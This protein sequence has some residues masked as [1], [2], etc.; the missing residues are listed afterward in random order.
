M[1]KQ[2]LDKYPYFPDKNTLIEIMDNSFGTIFVTDGEGKIIFFSENQMRNIMQFEPEELLGKGLQDLYSLGFADRA[3]ACAEVIN[4]KEPVV[5]RLRNQNTAKG[6]YSDR[7]IVCNPVFDDNG[8]LKMTVGYSM[9][10][11]MLDSMVLNLIK[12]KENADDALSFMYEQKAQAAPLVSKDP[13]TMRA[14]D[15]AKRVAKLDTTV[16]IYGE[17]GSGKD[18]MARYLHANSPRANKVF[19][20]VNSAALPTELIES[21]LFGY[22]KGSF[23]GASKGGKSGLFEIA[24]DGTIFL[25]EIA[26]IPYPTQSKLLRVLENGEYFKVGGNKIQITNARIIA[27]T[28]RDLKKMVEE[29]KFREDLYYRLDIMPITVPPLRLRKADIVDLANSFLTK[30]NLKYHQKQYFS[31]KTINAFLSYNW[32]GNV[33]ELRNIVERLALTTDGDCIDAEIKNIPIQNPAMRN[34]PQPP[35]QKPSVFSFGDTYKEALRTFEK[36]YIEAVIE[37]CG[38]NITAAAKELQLHRTS[39]Y[40]KLSPDSGKKE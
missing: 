40:K 5:T 11:H 39:L 21:E 32:P 30:C 6:V 3:L 17:S 25:D 1:E 10:E 33:R 14:Y 2:N 13:V 31:E 19:L 37:K 29:G 23:T 28:N 35:A 27:A 9:E 16:I 34:A 20:P 7:V 15:L 8:K 36:E 4:T 38:G 18:V 12:Q 24:N 26:E 22:E